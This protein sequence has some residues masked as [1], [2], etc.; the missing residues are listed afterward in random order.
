MGYTLTIGNAEPVHS[1]D[2][3]ELY[4]AWD[5]IYITS[6]DAPTFPND[7]MTGNSSQRS[8]SYSAWAEFCRAVGLY[9][10]FYDKYDG[11][12]A[13]HPG[14]V[15]LTQSHADQIAAALAAYPRTLPPGFAE[16]PHFDEATGTLWTPDEGKYDA[17]L[18]RLLWLDYWVRYALTNCETPALRNT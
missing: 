14:C 4:A 3:G 13:S 5:V 16:W 2:D 17:K 8:P 1:K 15:M 9:E 7:E 12:L 10:L 11:L 18:A 6:D